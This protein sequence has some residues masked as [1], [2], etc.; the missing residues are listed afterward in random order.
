MKKLAMLLAAV[1]AFGVLG[2]AG[3]AKKEETKKE[4]TKKEEPKKEEA[5]EEKK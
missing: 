2:F 5:K 4:E 1:F 3:C